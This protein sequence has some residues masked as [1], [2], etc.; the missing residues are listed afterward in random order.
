[1]RHLK[2]TAYPERISISGNVYMQ[3]TLGFRV[4]LIEIMEAI[5]IRAPPRKLDSVCAI[6]QHVITARMQDLS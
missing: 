2:K 3:K 6:P 4:N 1:M 5:K